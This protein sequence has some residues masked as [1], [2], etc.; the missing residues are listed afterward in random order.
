MPVGFKNG[1]DGSL[2]AAVDGVKAAAAQHVFFGLDNFG[3]GAIVETAG[4]ADC[5]V[6]LRGGSTGPNHDAESVSAAASV[7]AKAGLPARVMIDCSHANSGKDHVRQAEV[8]KEIAARIGAGT[9]AS[10]G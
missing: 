4:N 3:R 9:P 6:I 2:Q 8:A 10:A 7:L 1:T 5:H